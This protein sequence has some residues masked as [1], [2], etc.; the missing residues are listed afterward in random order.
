MVETSRKSESDFAAGGLMKI[1]DHPN[2]VHWPPE[3]IASFDSESLSLQRRQDLVLKEVELLPT[4]P[5][6]YHSY[7]RLSAGH[8]RDVWKNYRSMTTLKSYKGAKT[9]K[10]YRSV[11][12]FMK[13]SEFLD[14]LYK[15][16][17][18]NIGRTIREIGDVEI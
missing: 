16:L 11:I 5:N 3:W 18:G 15:K 14:R 7:I 2:L 4:A 17:K 12:I 9:E 13:D 8:Q 1:K 10:T 6:D